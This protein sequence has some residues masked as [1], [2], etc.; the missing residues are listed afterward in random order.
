MTDR[1]RVVITGV[2]MVS[3]YGAGALHAWAQLCAGQSGVT[4]ISRFDAGGFPTRIAAQVPDQCWVDVV[5]A[6][7]TWEGRG[8]IA[9]LAAAAAQAAVDDAN[10]PFEGAAER[11]GVVVATG[12]GVFEHDEIFGTTAGTRASRQAPMD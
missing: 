1:R 11:A 12:T 2:G 5:H 8:R 7:P 4:A 3:A 6:T 10:R 9:R